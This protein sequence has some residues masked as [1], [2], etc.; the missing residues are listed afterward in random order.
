MTKVTY[1]I[2]GVP[3]IGLGL[4]QR[5][6]GWRTIGLAA[7]TGLGVAGLEQI[8]GHDLLRY[9]ADLRMAAAG[10]DVLFRTDGECFPAEYV[11]TICIRPPR[12]SRITPSYDG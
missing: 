5:Q 12:K 1:A 11:L 7:I 4:W 10:E 6:V 2:A 8:T 9:W 3:L